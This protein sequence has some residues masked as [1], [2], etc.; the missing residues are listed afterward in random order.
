MNKFIWYPDARHILIGILVFEKNVY[1][2]WITKYLTIKSWG[3][4]YGKMEREPIHMMSRCKAYY[5]RD[6]GVWKNVYTVWITKYLTIKC[7]GT[8]Y[9]RMERDTTDIASTMYHGTTLDHPTPRELWGL[10][11]EIQF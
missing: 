6:L 1:T 9:G 7:W 5:D 3:T 8:T 10:H 4:T 2:L 11:I